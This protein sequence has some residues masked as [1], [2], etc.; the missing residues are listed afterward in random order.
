MYLQIGASWRNLA[1]LPQI[2]SRDTPQV[3]ENVKF[4]ISYQ[5]KP[6]SRV[7]PSTGRVIPVLV[8]LEIGAS[9]TNW[10]QI[11]HTIDTDT[12]KVMQSVKL[13]ITH[14]MKSYSR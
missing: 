12:Q 6:Y 4:H 11:P 14:Q 8:C 9:W 1:Q 13:H 2:M 3:I 10:A 5:M 7:R